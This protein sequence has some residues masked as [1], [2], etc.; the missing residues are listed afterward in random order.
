M[1][2]VECSMFILL[3]LCLLLAPVSSA[4]AAD[5]PNIVFI[6]MDDM[7]WDCMSIAGHPFLKTPNLDRIAREGA[8]FK[9]GFVTYPLCSP[10]RAS[11]FTGSYGHKH[12]IIGNTKE[13]NEPSHKLDTYH[14][15]LQRSGYRTAAIGKWH[16]GND[17]TPRPGFDHWAVFKGQGQYNDGAFNVNGTQ[18]KTTG[19]VTDVISDFAADFIKQDHGGKPF[20]LYVGHKAVHG[21]FKPA[22]RHKD[23]FADEKLPTRPNVNDDLAGKKAIDREFD[24][25]DRAHPAYGVTDD[26]IRN[27]LR[28]IVAVD[29]GV[30]K[31]LAAL[32]E[33]KQL[34]NTFIVF[35]SDNGFFW[36]EH[37]LGDKRAAYEES[38]R[39]PMVARYPRLIKTGTQI[40]Q[41]VLDVDF[42]PTFCDL[43]QASTK[44]T[45][46]H[47]RS[48]LPLFTGDGQPW[49]TS[50]LFEYFREPAYGNVPTWH[51]VRTDRWKYIHYDDL[52][53]VDELYDLQ[54]DPYELKN[55]IADPAN[56]EQ[57]A[58]MKAELTKLLEAAK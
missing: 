51:A 50:A 1:F 28:C 39:V 15:H 53:G 36:N 21:P 44:P 56:A 5:R 4:R 20:S 29:E 23:L 47:G 40:E 55:V 13:Y 24:F 45:S 52:E 41:M 34:D 6:L 10:A 46:L 7:R 43:A 54:N 14:I 26:L 18:T 11:F 19:Y 2:D 30:G 38:I 16:M 42:P 8:Y 27:Q 12:G 48:M 17:D 49:R 9:N 58:T 33:T 57:L 22:E 3:F 37:K 32:E 31:I 35:T 25:Q